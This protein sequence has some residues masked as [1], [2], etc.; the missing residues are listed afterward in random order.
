[1]PRQRGD[2]LLSEKQAIK[3]VKE[4]R[5]PAAII[6][7]LLAAAML[8]VPPIVLSLTPGGWANWIS[9]TTRLF[10][11]YA[12]TLIFMNIVTGAMAPYFYAIF[13]AREEYLVHVSTGAL[14]FLF[15]LAHGLIV[16]TQRYYRGFNAAWLIGPVALIML[17]INVWVALDR[18]RL[19]SIWRVIHQVNYVIFIG[20]FIKAVLIGSDLKGTSGAQQALMVIFS[21]YVAIAALAVIARVRRY[22]AAAARR[23]KAKAAKQTATD[24]ADG[25]A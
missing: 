23:R 7:A 12:F 10:G 14:G 4:R 16:I 17:V 5:R 19:K 15:A 2:P 6:L 22:R 21:A 8:A 24:A 13:G 1:L 20:V 25:E 9:W 11:L 18:V 3:Y